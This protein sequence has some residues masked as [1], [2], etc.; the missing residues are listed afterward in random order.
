MQDGLNCGILQIWRIAVLA[1]NA[2]DQNPHSRACRLPVLPIH[3][4]VA[5]QTIQQLLRNDAKLIVAHDLN[6]ALV[7]GERVIEGYF[8]LAEPFLLPAL[9]RRTDVFGE[10]DQLLKDLRRR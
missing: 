10:L 7:L 3:G 6:R 2:F 1:E 8:L 5:L 4:S 9:V